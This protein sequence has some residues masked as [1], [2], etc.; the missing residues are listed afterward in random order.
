MAKR[1]PKKKAGT[2]VESLMKATKKAL[3]KRTTAT[4]TKAK[5]KTKS[6]VTEKKIKKKMEKAKTN[7]KFIRV[8]ENDKTS[9]FIE[10]GKK[11][12]NGEVVWAFYGVE[13]KLGYH[14][15]R[16]K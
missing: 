6:A 5:T 14:Y 9:K 3:R 12:Q 8:A 7:D 16:I 11:V 4:K 2:K 10:M 15:Y 13:G 1:Q